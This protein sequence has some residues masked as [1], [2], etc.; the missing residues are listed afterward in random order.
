VPVIGVGMLTAA[1]LMLVARP[2][3]VFIS[4]LFSR[5]DFREKTMISWVGLRGAVPIILATFPLLAG[6]DQAEMIFNVVFF[7]VLTSALLQ[8]TSIPLVSRLLGLEEPIPRRIRAPLEF[9]PGEEHRGELFE[10]EI[11]QGS[12]AVEKQIIDLGLPK[13]ALIVLVQRNSTFFVPEGGTVL[14]AGDVLYL[15]AD[16]GKKE[17]IGRLVKG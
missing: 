15:M 10:I 11:P 17:E 8:G 7:I 16:R 12:G 6:I 3:S 14:E 13:G 5:L 2:L 9:E 4:L 1:F